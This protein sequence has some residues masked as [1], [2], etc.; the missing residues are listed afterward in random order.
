VK[1]YLTDA[2]DAWLAFYPPGVTPT[3]AWGST[4]DQQ[5]L[6]HLG[7]ANVAAFQ[8]AQG[9]SADGVAGADTRRALITQYMAEDGTTLPSTAEIQTH[10]CGESH[11]EIPTADGV[12]EERN[13]RVEVF[14]FEGAVTPAPVNPCPP[15]P[16]CVE[17]AVWAKTASDTIDLGDDLATV[18]VTVTDERGAPVAGAQIHLAG[19]VPENGTT[20]ADGTLTLGDVLPSHYEAFAGKTGFASASTQIDVPSGGNV[21]V[22]LQLQ[23][24]KGALDVLVRDPA[25]VFVAAAQ[26]V[27]NGPDGATDTKPADAAGHALFAPVA[28]GA[29][30]IAVTALD[31]AAGAATATVQPDQT[32]TAVV[33]LVPLPPGLVNPK[34]GGSTT[35]PAPTEKL[36]VLLRDLSGAPIPALEATV[37]AGGLRTFGVSDAAGLLEVQIPQGAKSAVVTFM[38]P[39]ADALVDWPLQLELPPVSG[40]AGAV[41]RLRNLGYPADTRLDFSV[42]S[43]QVDQALPVTGA[44]DDATR[45]KLVEMHGG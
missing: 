34:L 44:L 43:F 40:D 28:A 12:A 21:P 20:A 39:D 4:E 13:R 1:A 26:V 30:Q 27:A 35:P 9:L 32:A 42:F 17:H 11:P 22:A 31:F 14:V 45:A 2:V 10:G 41:G 16:G 5:M 19:I 23:S 6:S 7:F 36:V 15:P 25:N 3:L 38:P 8:T 24:A 33:T 29:W 37:L 18:V